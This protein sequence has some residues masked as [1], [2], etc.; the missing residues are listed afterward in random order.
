MV[1]ALAYEDKIGRRG[2]RLMDLLDKER[3]TRKL[4]ENLEE[5]N[6][7]LEKMLGEQAVYF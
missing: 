5:K 7:I 1:S 4:K 2:F 6:F 3:F